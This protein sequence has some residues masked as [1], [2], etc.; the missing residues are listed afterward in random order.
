MVGGMTEERD[1]EIALFLSDVHTI[2][3]I[4]IRGIDGCEV[5]PRRMADVHVER[6]DS[7][8][9]SVIVEPERPDPAPASPRAERGADAADETMARLREAKRRSR[10]R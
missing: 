3:P 5:E 10:D 6:V 8:G 9:G 7:R 4:G 2:E 1:S